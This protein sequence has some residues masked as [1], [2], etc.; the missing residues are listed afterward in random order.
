MPKGVE[1]VRF[2]PTPKAPPHLH[3]YHVTLAPPAGN[4][5]NRLPK[6]PD[7]C[8]GPGSPDNR[9]QHKMIQYVILV[10]PAT[11]PKLQENPKPQKAHK[12][13]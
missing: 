6:K 10:T 12:A 2:L 11:N 13:L 7:I 9:P 5:G 3:L 8:L 4:A 1:Q